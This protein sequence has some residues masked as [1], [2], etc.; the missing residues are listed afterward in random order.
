MTGA[1]LAGF[2]P[3]LLAVI[4]LRAL[5]VATFGTL[6]YLEPITVVAPAWVLFD[7]SLNGLQLAG[8]VLII[9][10]GIAQA[11]LLNRRSAVEAKSGMPANLD[12]TVS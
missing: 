2:L 5:P 4:T 10:A 6:A 7:Q 8:G 11:L 3:I 1:F 9:L 12:S